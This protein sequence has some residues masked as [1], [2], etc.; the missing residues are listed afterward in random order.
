MVEDRLR[1]AVF[2]SV[3]T[4]KV[5]KDGRTGGS[6]IDFDSLSESDG[7]VTEFVKEQSKSDSKVG[8]AL[9]SFSCSRRRVLASASFFFLEAFKDMS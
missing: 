4:D 7:L 5:S 2:V 9:T 6:L 8:W 3:F 1:L